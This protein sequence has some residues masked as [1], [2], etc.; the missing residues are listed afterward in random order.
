M[1]ELASALER[2]EEPETLAEAVSRYT[3][4]QQDFFA[5]L[6]HRHPQMTEE[7]AQDDSLGLV[8]KEFSQLKQELLTEFSQ[9]RKEMR[10]M[11][12]N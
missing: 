4:W 3:A 6:L 2:A 12:Q 5:G 8:R 11:L 10:T 1:Q 9:L 7:A